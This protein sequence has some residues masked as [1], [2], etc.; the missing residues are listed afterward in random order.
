[1]RDPACSVLTAALLFT[2]RIDSSE[3]RRRADWGFRLVASGAAAEV[4][5]LRDGSAADSAGLREGDR[6][7]RING[8][9]LGDARTIAHVTRLFRGGDRVKLDVERGAAR[10]SIAFALRAVPEEKIAGCDVRYGSVVTPAGYRVRT[11]FTRPM[12][13][14]G[15]LPTIVF[16]PW[17]SCDAVEGVTPGDGWIQLLHALAARSGWALYRV[18]KPG[19]GDSEGPDCSTNDLATDLAAFRAAL[20]DVRQ[21][22]GVDAERIVLFGGSIGGAL[23]PVLAAEH[24]VAGLIVSGGFSRTWLEHMLEI[25]RAR[26]TLEGAAPADV[27]RALR[28]YADFYTLYLN[29]DLTPAQVLARRPDLASLWHDAPDGQYGRPAAYYQQLQA[30]NVEQ[31]WAALDVPV[32]VLDGEYD[33]IMSRAEAEHIERLV[34]A[35]RPGRVTLAMVPRTDHNLEVYATPLDAYRGVGGHFDGVLTDRVIAWLRA[36]GARDERGR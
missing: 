10:A 5:G 13:A 14:R 2:S 9:A 20:A 8:A 4:R 34:N 18:E 35:R 19:S 29:H 28:G 12:G 15:A 33:W 6:V 30:L 26:M 32:L 17:L 7:L 16:I 21:M 27:H 22:D 25:E 1:M 23:A 24:P 31:A 36:L 11:V 3:L